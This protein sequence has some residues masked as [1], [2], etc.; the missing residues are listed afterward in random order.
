VD[1]RELQA[2]DLDRLVEI[3]RSEHARRVYVLDGGALRAVERNLEIATWSE[4][5]RAETTARLAGKLAEGG[6]AFGVLEDGRLVGLAVLG[7]ERIGLASHQLELAFLHVS[8]DHRRRGIA[9]ALL[10]RVCEQASAR[11]A[12]Q[13]YISA[14]DTDSAVDF[15]LAAGCDLADHLDPVLYAEWPSDIHLVLD[16]LS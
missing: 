10:R 3:D 11:G 5:E 12:T 6:A 13:L 9:R 2:G 4:D 14:S 7:G 15:Y 16:L 1:V 8:R